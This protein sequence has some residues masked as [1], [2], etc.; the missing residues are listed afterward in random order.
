MR[1]FKDSITG[2]DKDDD[3]EDEASEDPPRS[4]RRARPP[5]AEPEVGP[6][7]PAAGPARL[8]PAASAAQATAWPP[9]RPI[10]HE[11]RLALV[12]HLDELRTRLI[13]CIGAHRRVLVLLLAERP[14]ARD[15]DNRCSREGL[16]AASAADQLEQPRVFCSGAAQKRSATALRSTATRSAVAARRR[17]RGRQA[18]LAAP[19]RRA[20]RRRRPPRRP[21]N[22]GRQPITFGVTE[23]FLTTFTVAGYAAILL[24]AAVPPLPG[25]TPS[26]CRRS[27][28]RAPGAL[29]LMLLVPALFIAGVAFGYFVALPRAIDFL[30]NFNE[31]RS[32]S[33]S[34]PRTTTR[35][36]SSSWRRSGWCSRSRSLC[37]R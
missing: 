27:A 26:S 24:V 28:P 14:A 8:A 37:W 4:R 36:R 1:E 29:P 3:D 35:S 33:S 7:R 9:L 23:P 30:L 32:T 16:A 15:I 21:T 34:G 18:A 13:V 2:K 20:R 31:N 5:A 10:G 22:L 25:S 11:D 17:Q 6:P 19:P 12:E